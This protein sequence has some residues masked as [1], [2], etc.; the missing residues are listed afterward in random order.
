MNMK[1]RTLYHLAAGCLALSGSASAAVITFSA[2]SFLDEAQISTNGTL[3]EAANFGSSSTTQVLNGI[4]FTAAAVSSA[5]LTVQNGT[6]SS[7]NS[8][9]NAAIHTITGVTAAEGNAL[10]NFFVFGSGTGSDLVTLSG[11]TVGVQYEFQ[12]LFVDDRTNNGIPDRTMTVSLV[13]GTLADG[14]GPLDHT[15]SNVQLVTGTFT[16]SAL[17]QGFDISESVGNNVKINAYQLRV[18]PEP[19]VALLG[20]MAL[21][22]LLRRRR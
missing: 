3:V 18:V 4:T 17:T 15:S 5:N 21:L 13:G 1:N 10:F 8:N 6:F 12:V 20:S 14:T 7:N 16:A 19:S 11:L 9:Y 22:G 2:E